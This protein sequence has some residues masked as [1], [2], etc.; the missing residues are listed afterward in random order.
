MTAATTTIDYHTDTKGHHIEISSGWWSRFGEYEKQ[1]QESRL[2]V[3]E[4]TSQANSLGAHSK[5][6]LAQQEI[7]DLSNVPFNIGQLQ[8]IK[9][10]TEVHIER[11]IRSF[12]T[13]DMLKLY[14][15]L[16][17]ITMTKAYSSG[18]HINDIKL[19]MAKDPEENT[20]VIVFGVFVKANP[21]QAIAYWNAIGASIDM[22]RQRLTEYLKE[23]LIT[24]WSI[25]VRWF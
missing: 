25:Q 3:G 11:N 5:Q 14:E 18:L 9:K 16:L 23:L 1:I 8:Q 22:W 20:S 10:P 15:S 7:F 13:K 12:L 4:R 24:R 21:A 6:L 17:A 19:Y 2:L